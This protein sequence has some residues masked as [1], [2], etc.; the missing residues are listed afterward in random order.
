MKYS[1]KEHILGNGIA[2]GKVSCRKSVPFYAV[3]KVSTLFSGRKCVRR[4]CVH[5][6][7]VHPKD[8]RRKDVRRKDVH[9]KY[10]GVPNLGTFFVKFGDFLAVPGVA[11]VYYQ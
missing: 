5:R 2:V 8:V 6:K 11:V 10:V 3:G 7:S 4:K 9:R 1:E